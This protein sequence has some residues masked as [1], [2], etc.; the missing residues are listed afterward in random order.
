[1]QREPAFQETVYYIRDLIEN[2]ENQRQLSAQ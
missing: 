2:L 1:M